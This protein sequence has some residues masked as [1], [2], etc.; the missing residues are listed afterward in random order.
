MLDWFRF[1]VCYGI[2][3]S[4]GNIFDTL[5]AIF[6]NDGKGGLSLRE[7]GERAEYCFESTVSEKRTH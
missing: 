5:S 4:V 3:K 2:T 7:V 1:L 6:Q